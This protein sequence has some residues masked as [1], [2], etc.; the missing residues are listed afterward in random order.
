V[1]ST[2][3]TRVSAGLNTSIAELNRRLAAACDT[4]KCEF[5]DLNATMAPEGEL[6]ADGAR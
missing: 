4:D 1:L 3:F 2:L 5:V 6:A